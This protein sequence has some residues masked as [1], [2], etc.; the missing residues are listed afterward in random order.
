MNRFIRIVAGFVLMGSASFAHAQA[1]TVTISPGADLTATIQA[2]APGDTVCLNAG[3][4]AP[5]A[6]G[7]PNNGAFAIGR[8]VTVRGANGTTPSQVIL[9]GLPAADHAVYFT[10]YLNASASGAQLIGVTIQGSQGGVQI[11]NFTNLPAGRLTDIKLKDVIINTPSAG[12]CFGLLSQG[13]DRI[14]LDNVTITS[15]Q[16]GLFMIDTTDSLVMNSNV[17]RTGVAN[18]AGLGVVGGSGNRFINNTFGQP[19]SGNTYSF[20]GGGLVFYN[21]SDNRFENNLVQGAKEDAIDFTVLNSPNGQ[22]TVPSFN[23]YVGKNTVIHT[24][25]SEG[26]VLGASGIW[27]NCSSNGTW[28]YG[29]NVSGTAECGVCVW[30]GKSNMVLG[31]TFTNNG[32]VGTFVSGGLETEQYCTA[33]AGGTQFKQK[34]NTNFIL[35]N[36]NTFNVNDQM[37]IRNADNTVVAR[38]FSSPRPAFGGP[39]QTC[40]N[41]ACQAAYSVESDGGAITYNPG[42]ASNTTSTS[43]LNNTS[44]DNLRGFWVDSPATTGFFIGGNR[45]INSTNSRISSTPTINID[46]GATL[47]GNYWTQAPATGNPSTGAQQYTG[48]FHDTSNNTGRVI[49]RFPFQSENLGRGYNISISEPRAGSRF[50]AGT[51]RTVR[52]DAPGCVWIDVAMGATSLLAGAPNTGYGII[53]IPANAAIGSTTLTLTCRDAGGTIRGSATSSA[54]SVTDPSLTLLSPGRDD[55]F[56]AGQAIWVSWKNTNPAANTTVAIDYSTDAAGATWTNIA[57]LSSL[58]I[59]PVTSTRVTLPGAVTSAAYFAIR[60]RSGGTTGVP[61]NI[62]DQTDGVLAVRGGAGALTNVSAGRNY[63]MGQLER[64]EWTSPANSKLVTITAT[65]GVTQQVIADIPDRGHFDWI[66]ADLGPGALTLSLQFKQING[67]NIGAAV[68]NATAGNFRYATNITFGTPPAINPPGNGTLTATTNSGAAVTLTSTT[69]GIC[70]VAGNTVT[71]VSN[72]TCSITGNAGASGNF[73]PAPASTITFSIGQT[74]TIT[75][76]VQA[77][78]GVSTSIPLSASASSGLPVTFSSLTPGICSVTGGNTLTGNSV[79]SCIV[80][81]DQAGNGSFAAA[82]QVQRTLQALAPANI[83]RL[84]NISTRMQVLT[85]QDVLIG[86]LIIGGTQPKTV[87]IRARGPSLIPLGVPNALLNPVLQLFSGPTQIDANDNWQEHPNQATL[88]ASGFAPSNAFESAIYTTLNPGAYT[89]IVTGAGGT[90]GV[91]IIEVFEVNKPE[92]PLINIATRGQ[93]L[94]GGDV[95]IAGFIIQGNQPQTVAVRARGP[96]LGSQGV[97][98]PLQNPRLQLFSGQTEIANNDD[99]GTASN[100]AQ[101]TSSGFAPSDSRESVILMTLAPGAYTA[102]VTGVGGTTGVAIVEVFGL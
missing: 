100:A 58:N 13:N 78:L 72:G 40:T 5:P 90:T 50:A 65:V 35:S 37:V 57:S 75:F 101:I 17:V 68:N 94:T 48:V 28:I 98:G 20:D 45:T 76:N 31:N 24:A 7:F 81:A 60:I 95:M 22:P 52:W 23:N 44:V 19:K 80:A 6:P 26:R 64:L 39:L 11:L 18:A 49:D 15:Y 8:A 33:G 87:V 3:T 32:I 9:Q 2:R 84:V 54:F 21:T 74:Q 77:F 99:W 25:L 67:T 88:N 30:L 89:G 42:A 47:G 16:T 91:G 83:P 63:Q 53:T 59:N 43:I 14:V 85:G 66:P 46:R 55:T 34:P 93:V 62:A 36:A 51:K 29:N 82:P 56:N 70:T 97:V 4:Y 27:S 12:C 69:P 79:G 73:Q 61:G 1:C 86:G 71:G 102:I 41:G 96:S 38:N 92:I 10:N